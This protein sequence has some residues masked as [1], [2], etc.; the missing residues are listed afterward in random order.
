MMLNI[1][2]KGFGLTFLSVGRGCVSMAD[3]FKDLERKQEDL[4]RQ[5][6][7]TPKEQAGKRFELLDRAASLIAELDGW[8][9]VVESPT[10]SEKRRQLTN[11]SRLIGYR[12]ADLYRLVDGKKAAEQNAAPVNGQ[13][14]EISDFVEDK[15]GE[16]LKKQVFAKPADVQVEFR[17]LQDLSVKGGRNDYVSLIEQVNRFEDDFNQY[18][19]GLDARE[20]KKWAKTKAILRG[21][22][23]RRV[24]VGLIYGTPPEFDMT[25]VLRSDDEAKGE[26]EKMIASYP[27]K[28][29]P[30]Y[31]NLLDKSLP[32]HPAWFLFLQGA[33]FSKMTVIGSRMTKVV[34]GSAHS[35]E[36]TYFVACGVLERMFDGLPKYRF[37]YVRTL[38]NFLKTD[39]FANR[40]GY[41]TVMLNGLTGK[42]EDKFVKEQELMEFEVPKTHEKPKHVIYG[43]KVPEREV[44]LGDILKKSYADLPQES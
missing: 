28:E 5:A 15:K 27:E 35:D 24:E 18:V 13:V 31:A 43:V 4:K 25:W 6:W 11:F 39:E 7:E 17:R 42:L 37:E 38:V 44:S 32:S 2:L 29:R 10:L 14:Q 36:L 33:Y 26:V 20:Q 3:F 9:G 21:E 22:L 16:E 30:R 23:R 12:P 40:T 1:G 41:K 19:S 34:R 8:Q